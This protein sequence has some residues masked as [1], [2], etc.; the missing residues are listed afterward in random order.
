MV[1][2]LTKDPDL[3]PVEITL[4]EGQRFTGH[5]IEARIK[6]REED[7]SP[8]PRSTASFS[9]FD[10]DGVRVETKLRPTGQKGEYLVSF[11]PQKSGIYKLKIGTSAG[12][13]EE[14]VGVA[15]LLDDLD[16]APNYEQL[17][18]I[19]AST[20][21]RFLVGSNNLLEEIEAYGKRGQRRFIEETHLPLWATP[22]I[23]AILLAL[24][25]MEWYLRR[26]WG[27]I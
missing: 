23:L 9:V 5:E 16:A 20:G 10:P 18:K 11:L 4:P 17:K 13:L 8:N 26:K 25:G 15:E 7:L 1:R 22:Y 2:W 21:G 19:A 14:S 24:L 3:N 6:L 12:S 27:L